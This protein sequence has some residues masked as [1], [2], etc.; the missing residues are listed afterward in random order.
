MFL[1]KYP[2]IDPISIEYPQSGMIYHSGG[3]WFARKSICYAKIQYFDN[4]IHLFGTHVIFK[5][6]KI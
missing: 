6:N 4:I 5:N 2:I 1:S 3:D